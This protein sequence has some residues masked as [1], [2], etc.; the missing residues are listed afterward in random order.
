MDTEFDLGGRAGADVTHVD[1][2][3][4]DPHFL[5]IGLRYCHADVYKNR[6]RSH[7]GHHVLSGVL[8]VPGSESRVF[9]AFFAFLALVDL[10]V[11]VALIILVIELGVVVT[12]FLVELELGI[13]DLLIGSEDVECAVF[14]CPRRFAARGRADDHFSWQY[15][16]HVYLQRQP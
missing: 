3:C 14:D 16:F 10:L 11:F 12:I 9:F 13:V 7:G 8:V 6:R 4:S 1:G 2:E 5:A 15:R